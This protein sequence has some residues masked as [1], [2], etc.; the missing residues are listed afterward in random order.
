MDEKRTAI[1]MM[2]IQEQN[3]SLQWCHGE[4]NLSDGLTKKTAKRS[5]NVSMTMD[6]YGAS[7]MTMKLSVPESLRQGQR[8][9]D[10]ETTCSKRDLNKDWVRAFVNE[11]L[12]ELLEIKQRLFWNPKVDGSLMEYRMSLYPVL[13]LFWVCT[14]MC[15][16]GNT[17]TEL[18]THSTITSCHM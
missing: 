6:V 5:W 12:P 2:G 13:S 3:A 18:I 17:S 14:N 1:E 15:T 9:L 10:E 11:S 8:L 7:Y 4:A 16:I